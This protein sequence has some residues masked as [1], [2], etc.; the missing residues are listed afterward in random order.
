MKGRLVYIRSPMAYAIGD[1]KHLL[2]KLG[3]TMVS[4]E[5][6]VPRG[7]MSEPVVAGEKCVRRKAGGKLE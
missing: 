1:I 6:R 7:I 5:R 2:Y 4:V 3:A